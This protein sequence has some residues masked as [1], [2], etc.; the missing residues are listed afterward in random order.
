[1]AKVDEAPEDRFKET[2]KVHQITECPECGNEF[3]AVFDTGAYDVEM[4]DDEISDEVTCMNAECGHT[5]EAEYTGWTHRT[6]AG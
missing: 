4:V 2:V 1:M 6:D 5:W 3:E